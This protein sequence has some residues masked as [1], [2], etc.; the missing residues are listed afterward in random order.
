VASSDSGSS[1]ASRDRVSLQLVSLSFDVAPVTSSSAEVHTV[2]ASVAT[3][4][5]K[6]R[7]ETLW[8]RMLW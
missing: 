8:I 5:V 3:A 6:V 7:H 1:A 4:L 2:E